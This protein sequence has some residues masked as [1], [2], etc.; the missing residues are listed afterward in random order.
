MQQSHVLRRLIATALF[1]G[2]GIMAGSAFASCGEGQRECPDENMP[3]MD[4]MDVIGSFWEDPYDPADYT[5]WDDPSCWAED[6]WEDYYGDDPGGGGGSGGSETYPLEE[7]PAPLPPEDLDTGCMTF[8]F[9]FRAEIGGG[10]ALAE[11][12]EGRF[13]QCVDYPDTGPSACPLPP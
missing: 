8:R 9:D 1:V 6:P 4:R 11:F 13:T 5:C 12:C 7:P 3:T 10:Y 2:A